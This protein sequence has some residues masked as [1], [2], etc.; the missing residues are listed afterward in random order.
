M[1]KYGAQM[2]GVVL[3]TIALYSHMLGSLFAVV[4]GSDI[5]HTNWFLFL[6]GHTLQY[7][8]LYFLFS[9]LF[10]RLKSPAAN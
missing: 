10:S 8:I 7:I 2:D 9:F 6:F 5:N 3:T 4:L 1:F